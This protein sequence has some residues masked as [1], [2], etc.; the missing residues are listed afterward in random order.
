MS[1]R[2][3]KMAS[4]TEFPMYIFMPTKFSFHK[5]IRV[6]AAI[7]KY[8]KVL[9]PKMQSLEKY[10]FEMLIAKNGTSA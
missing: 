3:E 4:R 8:M 1:I 2:V 6:T 9:N 5:V 7:L 10:R